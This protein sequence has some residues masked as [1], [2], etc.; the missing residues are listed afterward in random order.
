[1][2]KS[3]GDRERER[4]RGE[5][6]LLLQLLL[7]SPAFGR[8]SSGSGQVEDYSWIVD[9][10]NSLL[11]FSVEAKNI[12]GNS[13]LIDNVVKALQEAEKKILAMNAQ[14]GL[15]E[16]EDIKFE[17]TYFQSFNEAKSYLRQT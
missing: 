8:P 5:M 12:I 2:G 1:M 14:L 17:G 3:K 4:E 11:S 10:F 9:P 13:G 16:T 6:N 7:I 15:L